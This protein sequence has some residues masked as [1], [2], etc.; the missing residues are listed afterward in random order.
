DADGS[1]AMQLTSVGGR[2]VF[3]STWSPDSQK[4][5]FYASIG[6]NTDIYVISANGGT[7]RRLTTEPGIDHWPC[8]SHDG[9]WLYF[10]S[11]RGGTDEIW[12]MPASGGK[13]VQVTQNAN[14]AD[15]P[16]ESPDG[17]FVYYSKGWPF[18]QSVWRV[19]AEGGEKTKVLDAVHPYGL[20]TVGKEGIYFFT[21]PDKK[22]HSDL[23]IYEFATGKTRKILTIERRVATFIAVSPD[24]RTILYPQV[25]EAG[26]DLMLVENFR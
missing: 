13:A 2:T 12:R 16:H 3:G 9:Q 4:I 15:L 17:K 11:D 19:P 18:P 25:D 26:S 23:S 14:G 20:W 22:R 8:W 5:A 24:G 21:V 1:N 6:G 10:S 7:P